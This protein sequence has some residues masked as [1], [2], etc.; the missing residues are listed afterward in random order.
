[1]EEH[2]S[3]AGRISNVRKQ[4]NNLVFYDIKGDGAK[5]QVMANSKNFEANPEINEDFHTL[6]N[7]IR[8]GDIIGAKGQ[9]GKTKTGEF[10]INASV[11]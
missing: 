10:T 8:R 2:V 1:M 3:I 11:V 9:P 5:I 6:H 4:G 7:R